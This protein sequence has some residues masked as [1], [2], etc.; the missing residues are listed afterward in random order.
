MNRELIS[1]AISNIDSSF[2]AE[3]MTCPEPATQKTPERTSKMGKYENTSK[4]VRSG[5]LF[6]L[7]LAACLVFALA[8]TAFAA[9][10]FGIRDMFRTPNREL[11][12]GADSYIQQHTEAAEGEDW[13]CRITESLCDTSTVMV[14]VDVSGGDRYI[15]APMDASPTDSVCIIGLTG[16]Q[17]LEEYA[18]SQGKKLLF[19]GAILEGNEQLGLTVGSL[20]FENR[21]DRE[22]TILI[23]NSK[24]VSFTEADAVCY[25]YASEADGTNKSMELTF[26]LT[27]APSTEAGNYAPVDPAAIPGLIVGDA[28]VTETPLGISV[29]FMETVTD[30]DAYNTI[31]KVEIDGIEYGE[32]GSVLED[33]GNWY[34]GFSM[35]Q[36]TLTDTLTV[37]YYDWDKQPIGQIVFQKK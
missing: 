7:I 33:D 24:T 17:T 28:T 19:V 31:M 10:W 22:M 9:D 11:P 32:G 37:H 36:G 1:K 34:F 16:E 30:Q 26:T 4:G 12:E 35:G 25:V 8:I 23:E 13:S 20:Q 6:A 27:Q 29:R 18:A 14:T 15:L 3:A 2:I 5:R 21:S